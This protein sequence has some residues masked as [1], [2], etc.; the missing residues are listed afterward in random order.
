MVRTTKRR[1]NRVL[2][3]D[4]SYTTLDGRKRRFRRDAELQTR[5]GALVEERRRI[6]A[7]AAKGSPYAIV[8]ETVAKVEAE[9]APPPAAGPTFRQLADAYFNIY[10]PSRLKVTS[11]RAYRAVLDKHLLPRIG[12]KPLAEITSAT[13]R[14]LD[15]TM[16]KAG[17]GRI[18]R[19]QA[20]CVLRSI[21]CR[22]AVEAGLLSEP[23]RLPQMPRK[24]KKIPEVLTAEQATRVIQ[25]AR[26][27]QHRLALLLA[28]HAGLRSCEIR[29]LRVCD[30]DL[31]AGMLRIGQAIS[32]GVIDT[33]KSGHDREVPLTSTLRKALEAATAKRPRDALVASS[34]RGIAWGQKGLGAMFQRLAQR[35]GIVG[36]T[37]HHLRH[38]FVTALLDKGVGAHI[39]KE[40]AGHADLTTTERYAHALRK[41]KRAAIDVLEGIGGSGG[42]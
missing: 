29:G 6:T 25:A 17:T 3:I 27:P 16:A 19:R 30:V 18:T 40:L 1:G 2:V 38:G 8:D 15:A 39:V 12:E 34:A 32:Y 11:Q 21:V 35:A 33:P 14:E 41:N 42:E 13:V 23:P 22:Y 28:F 20:Q 7:V 36:S 26:S 4:F 5:A 9:Q 24:S 10:A 37:M 31:E